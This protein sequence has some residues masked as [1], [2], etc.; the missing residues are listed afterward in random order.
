MCAAMEAVNGGMSIYSTAI[1]YGVPRM[2]LQNRVSGRVVHGKKLG[3]KPYLT[4]T[5]KRR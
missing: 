2:T 3:P 5:E 1:E 4:S